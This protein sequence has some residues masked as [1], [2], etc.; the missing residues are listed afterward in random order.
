MRRDWQ[1]IHSL[2]FLCN[3]YPVIPTSTAVVAQMSSPSSSGSGKRKRTA[4]SFAKSST[5]DLLQPSSRDASGEDAADSASQAV[6]SIKHKKSNLAT[7]ASHPPTKRA[8]TRSNAAGQDV[9]SNND[10]D[11]DGEDHEKPEAGLRSRRR[12]K[13]NATKDQGDEQTEARTAIPPPAKGVLQ[14]PVGYHT[15]PPPTDRA[16]RVY[17]DGVFDL[18]HLGYGLFQQFSS[19]VLKMSVGICVSSSKPRM[20][21]QSSTCLMGSPGTSKHIS[22]KA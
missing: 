13:S 16:V 15:N 17:A 2:I 4:P 10:A 22:G 18:F 14:D 5:A 20:L 1:E 9:Q 21:F 12:T 8:R 11:V 7:E 6:T 19:A 3:T